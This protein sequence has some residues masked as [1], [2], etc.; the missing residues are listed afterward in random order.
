MRRFFDEQSAAGSAS[1]SDTSRACNR[2]RAGSAPATVGQPVRHLR[3]CDRRKT[4]VPT[5]SSTTVV[6]RCASTTPPARR[7]RS[8]RSSRIAASRTTV[9]PTLR[10]P[11][12]PAALKFPG[13]CHVR[14]I[15][16]ADA[17]TR[18]RTSPS[19]RSS[20]RERTGGDARRPSLTGD[21]PRRL[22]AN[23]AGAHRGHPVCAAGLRSPTPAHKLAV[24]LV[25]DGLPPA[26]RTSSTPRRINPASRQASASQ[27]TS[28]GI[29]AIA[30][31]GAHARR[32]NAPP[33]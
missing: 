25:T 7:T 19:V 29:A 10:G 26:S 24:V 12:P 6:T 22:H 20:G 15:C 16:D 5:G 33:S 31:D 13:Y 30:A 23:G 3:P 21:E 17:Y 27:S 32:R 8:A 14:D 9:R 11:V 28:P 1:A 4:C 18:R 2:P